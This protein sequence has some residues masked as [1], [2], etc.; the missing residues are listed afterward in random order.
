VGWV[1]ACVLIALL[2]PVMGMLYLDV[3]EAKHEV[4]Q[5]VEKVEKLRR[6]IERSKRDKD[7]NDS[8]GAGNN[9]LP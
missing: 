1:A 2:L 7:R 9:R 5:Q 8:D 3:L 6:E 4:K